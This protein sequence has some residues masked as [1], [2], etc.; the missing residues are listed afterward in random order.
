MKKDLIVIY[1]GMTATIGADVAHWFTVS[2]VAGG[3]TIIYTALKIFEWFHKKKW[4]TK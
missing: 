4:R 2:N 1:S 3:L